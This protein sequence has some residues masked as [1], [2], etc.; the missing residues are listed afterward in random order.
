MNCQA[1]KGVNFRQLPFF[2]FWNNKRFQLEKC[3]NCGL[4]T[5]HPKPSAE[6]IAL[7]YSEDYF[8]H[9]H[10]GLEE[11]Q[12]TYEQLKDA[13]SM[14]DL[15]K[16]LQHT[17]LKAKPDAKSFFEI[18]AAMGHLLK[19]A[20]NMGMVV[21]GLEISEPANKKAREKFGFDL[22]QGDFE[23]LDMTSEYGQWDVVYGGDVF[24]HFSNPAIVV[25]KIHKMLRP[26]G[27]AYLIIPS[28]FNLFSTSVATFIFR[29]MG[30]EQ[31]LV[32]N[33]YHL[34]EYTSATA[35]KMMQTRFADVVI[36]NDIKRPSEM[37]QKNKSVA[38]RIKYLF[39][40]INFVFTKITGQR[41]DRVTIIA[42]K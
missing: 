35:K 14:A 17:V 2:Y 11:R 13:T 39:H 3:S 20:Q 16:K 9:G 4:V 6:E 37:N 27:I 31:R 32:D 7:L 21:S 12:K 23:E 28:T 36:L 41:G 25:D 26:G 40:F 15:E 38:Y 22:Y 8:D 10:H 18:G 34:Y 30:R 42:R 29:L 19:A 5:I 24:E 1:C 33:P